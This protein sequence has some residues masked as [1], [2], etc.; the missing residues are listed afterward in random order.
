MNNSYR[1]YSGRVPVAE[2]LFANVTLRDDIKSGDLRQD[3]FA[4]N[5][6]E[7]VEGK[8]PDT[9]RDANLFFETSHPSDGLR[10]LLNEALGRITGTKPNAPSIIRL[11]TS[12]G[13]G[14]T[15]S[16][17]GLY[18]GARREVPE[19]R[20]SE[21]MDL[22]YLPSAPVPKIAVF[23]GDE[24][25]AT[26][27]FAGRDGIK[28][29][30]LW[31]HIALQLGGGAAYEHVKVDD[32]RMT[33]PGAEAIEALIGD[34]M[35]IVMIDEIARYLTVAAGVKTGE[36]T[37]AD[38]TVAFMMSL[39][40]AVEA[41]PHAVLVVTTTEAT[42]VFGEETDRFLRGIGSI[43]ARKEHIIRPTGESDLAAILARRLFSDV[44]RQAAKATATEY[45]DA[46]AVATA[47]GASVPEHMR[48]ATWLQAIERAY[49]FHPSLISV[50]DKRI[51]TMPNFQHTRGA[52]RILALAV[53]R[54]WESQPDNTL[55]IHTHHLD[56]KVPAIVE[57]VTGH[58]GRT[59]FKAVIEKDIASAP[60]GDL[61][62]SEL[63]DAQ[64]GG[65]YAQN[66]ATTIY[67]WSLTRDIPGVS[68]SALLGSVFA[69][70]DDVNQY[71]RALELLT[72]DLELGAWYIAV[73][74]RGGFRF[75]TEAAPGKV[76]AEIR[77]TIKP[78]DVSRKC[79]DILEDLFKDGT[80]KVKRMWQGANVPDN[81]KD[82]YLAIFNWDEFVGDKGVDPAGN[83]PHKIHDL[84]ANGPAG[85][86]RLYRNR[87]VIL[88]PDAT[89]H[90]A[91]LKSVREHI[92]LRTLVDSSENMARFTPDQQNKI[93]KDAQTSELEAKVAV[94][95]HMSLL[96]VPQKDGLQM[97]TMP[98]PNQADIRKNQTDTVL[99]QLE[100]LGKVL[101][102]GTNALA[103]L[104]LKTKLGKFFDTA[105]TTAALEER[106]ASNADFKIL[107][108]IDSLRTTIQNGVSNGDW[109]YHNPA[110]GD[111]GWAT[112]S[113]PKAAVE[114]SSQTFI[115]PPKSAPPEQAAPC[116]LCG[117][118]HNP[119]PCPP[120]PAPGDEAPPFDFPPIEGPTK[121]VFTKSGA[122]GPATTSAVAVARDAERHISAIDVDVDEVDKALVWKQFAALSGLIQAG[123]KGVNV[124]FHIDATVELRE[125]GDAVKVTFDGSSD[126]LQN[127][128][129]SLRSLFMKNDNRSALLK[130]QMRAEFATPQDPDSHAIA[131]VV[132]AAT[133]RGPAN[134][135]VTVTTEERA[136]V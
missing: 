54:L 53:R 6:Q 1:A 47:A 12:L 134:C 78:T 34:D 44:S 74:P 30:T 100:E 82:A 90:Q 75:G 72:G 43:L 22:R 107:L 24:T 2:D 127:I 5:L 94:A 114:I 129:E 10:I 45:A 4:A 103:P 18:H 17:I 39:I 49:P 136:A 14:K 40:R 16:L 48:Q 26:S 110:L 95:S 86:P 71:V 131:A 123:A 101:V 37:L 93:R 8:G 50:L 116:P 88:A 70:G 132:Q 92:A 15:H 113:R 91:M 52:L 31:G 73:E 3:Q 11:E 79:L 25:G 102:A 77:E 96:F 13:G 42:D 125:Q 62:Q 66:L 120:R 121:T 33:A 57:E 55:L 27:G 118:P 117:R 35:T 115:Y 133:D 126:D 38:Q 97:V 109:E 21:F 111:R 9:Y 119:G 81:S 64:R 63:I 87:L 128:K 41:K 67:Y 104:F 108:D 124:R 20:L 99:K 106:F 130:A 58:I 36:N 29:Q 83:I 105:Q 85:G 19:S 65:R 23:V 69:P 112:K 89:Q 28:A 51:S 135:T 59:A 56:L 32:E 98:V 122:A 84:W 7:V 76:L 80:F 60:G 68:E 61:A 46:L